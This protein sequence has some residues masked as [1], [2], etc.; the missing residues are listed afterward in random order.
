MNILKIKK[1]VLGLF[2]SVF[3]LLISSSAFALDTLNTNQT[4]ANIVESPGSGS[5]S[6]FT[7][8]G[9]DLVINY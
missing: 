7:I 1:V 6:Y 2:S 8:P 4:Q 9:N 3:L 5:K